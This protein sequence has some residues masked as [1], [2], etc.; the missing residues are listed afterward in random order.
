MFAH[1]RMIYFRRLEIGR[2]GGPTTIM[3]FVIVIVIMEI[4]L[5]VEQ[6]IVEISAGIT[7]AQLR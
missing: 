7:V 4:V 3:I 1:R 5:I 6:V 2:L